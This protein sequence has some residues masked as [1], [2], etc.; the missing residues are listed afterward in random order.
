MARAFVHGWISLPSQGELYLEHGVPRQVRVADTDS[1]DVERLLDEVMDVTG[2]HATVGRWV[3]DE[4]AG[5][6]EAMVQVHP[7]DVTE[8]LRRLAQ[9]SAETFYDRYHKPMDA[10]DVDFD[11]E[12]YAQDMNE[13]LA[14]CG[15][16]W[17]QLD[18]NA[19][20]FTYRQAL[21][22]AVYDIAH[23]GH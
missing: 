11:D 6:M 18:D 17:G 23:E 14:V 8:V 2:L 13:A 22:R 12:A 16:H 1:V 5:E 20:R 9:R 4:E 7:E 21:H 10:G 19:L 3:S 15:L